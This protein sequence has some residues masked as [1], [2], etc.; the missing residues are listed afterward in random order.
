LEELENK[1]LIIIGVPYNNFRQK[2]GFYK[3]Y[4]RIF[5]RTISEMTFQ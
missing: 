3:G 5:V 4:P 1:N 2:P